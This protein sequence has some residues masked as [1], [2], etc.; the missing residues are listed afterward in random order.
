MKKVGIIGGLGPQST[1]LFYHEIIGLCQTRK[2]AEYPNMLINSM[3]M[4]E[5]V[6]LLNNKKEIIKLVKKEI[7]KIQN[8]VDF[9]VMPCNTIHFIINEIREFTK[10]PVL[11]IHEEVCKEISKSNVKKVGILGTTTTVYNNFYQEELK[12]VG[13]DFKVLD[14]KY[15]EQLNSLIFDKILRGKDYDKM[16]KLL[17]KDIQ[18]LKNKGC[19]S[20]ILACSE[21][22]LFINQKDVD[23]KLFPS[24]NILAKSVFE[25]IFK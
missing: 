8:H 13:I 19:D 11:A 1:E 17:K 18:L 24:T 4:W 5:F 2:E 9:I 3:N 21:L 20:V 12:K 15:E 23:I 6:H 10:V 22:P 16:H 14:E 7:D 25:K